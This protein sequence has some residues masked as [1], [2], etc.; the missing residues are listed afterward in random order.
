MDSAPAKGTKPVQSRQRS[1]RP[2]NA[3]STTI[4]R[5]TQ[6]P[7]IVSRKNHG[8]G[9][10]LGDPTV[11]TMTDQ[12]ANWLQSHSDALRR[13]ANHLLRD[14][15]EVD[16]ALQECYV[17]A[18]RSPPREREG[19]RAWL[20]AVLRNVIRK[21]SRSTQRRQEREQVRARPE[22]QAATIDV[23]A[24]QQSLEDLTTALASLGER[25]K[26]IIFLRYFDGLPAREISKS[27]DRPVEQVYR[28]LERARHHLRQRLDEERHDWRPALAGLIGLGPKAAVHP[29]PTGATAMLIKKNVLY[30]AGVATLAVVATTLWPD[31]VTPATHTVAQAISTEGDESRR[32]SLDA[33]TD[34]SEMRQELPT[35][36]SDPVPPSPFTYKLK[37]YLR[38]QLDLPYPHGLLM[39]APRNHPLNL[40][41][42]DENGQLNLKWRGR[43]PSIELVYTSPL[44]TFG[45]RRLQ[46]IALRAGTTSTI[47]L[48]TRARY[49]A[50]A[51]PKGI[52]FDDVT[53]TL[54]KKTAQAE[55]PPLQVDAQGFATFLTRSSSFQEKV[56]TG[57][58]VIVD[59]EV[60]V[61][62]FEEVASTSVPLGS[63]V[64][65]V[66]DAEGKPLSGVFVLASASVDKPGKHWTFSDD[67]GDYTITEVSQGHYHLRAGGGDHGI[68]RT[69]IDLITG[70]KQLWEPSLDRG[71]ELRAQLRDTD[72]KPLSHWRVEIAS[73]D[74][75]WI[76]GTVTDTDGRFALPNLKNQRHSADFYPPG[77][78]IPA[79]S[80]DDLWPQN[81][82]VDLRVPKAAV[83]VGSMLVAPTLEGSRDWPFG[84]V[85]V[86]TG[87]RFGEKQSYPEGKG[88]VFGRLPSGVYSVDTLGDGLG[89]NS[90]ASVMV[91]PKERSIHAPD[92]GKP[93]SFTMANQLLEDGLL[94]SD[95]DI[96]FT[97]SYIH[98]DLISSASEIVFS[99][100]VLPG[101]YLIESKGHR[102]E[103]TLGPEQ[104]SVEL[105]GDQTAKK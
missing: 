51:V 30:I 82:S 65:R 9:M 1:R 24:R 25:E 26:E 84:P 91:S 42:V 22:L 54:Y 64:G 90:P 14:P 29:Q 77:A 40:A 57:E 79:W 61:D 41:Q 4:P 102:R 55:R 104:V 68:A 85:F 67:N 100:L 56:E 81:G 8:P 89:Y 62:V 73:G 18:L 33:S 17:Q 97:A 66:L 83:E 3:R 23:V 69:E 44:A 78:A 48:R 36:V 76:D 6:I 52:S 75:D 43:T 63:I 88:F 105:T 50:P 39:L 53:S 71:L 93:T 46:R 5:Q 47:I 7:Q 72:G 59:E 38:T 11:A 58:S 21:R 34:K 15:N 20:E 12:T 92:L 28:D 10:Q 94:T 101:T 16:D 103:V 86:F 87:T 70:G 19:A 49:S 96:V 37:V 60:G 95:P 32:A 35:L 2:K 13:L 74:S 31:A 99:T 45:E 98:R 27:L 80:T